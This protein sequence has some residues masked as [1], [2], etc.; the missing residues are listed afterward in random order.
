MPVAPEGAAE[1]SSFASWCGEGCIAP[2][3]STV[4]CSLPFLVCVAATLLV[5]GGMAEG[6][7]TRGEGSEGEMAEDEVVEEEIAAVAG[8]VEGWWAARGDAS[9]QWML[10]Y[11]MRMR[12][13][14]VCRCCSMKEQ[15]A[16][17][18]ELE[19]SQ[20]RGE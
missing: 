13:R 10:K 18:E 9:G 12:S 8:A 11:M 15:S 3:P 17:N 14:R 4:R 5:E 20:L 19:Q 2:H 16:S 7:V 1:Q 6:E